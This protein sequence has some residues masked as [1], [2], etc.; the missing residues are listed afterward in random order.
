[1]NLTANL[2]KTA[3]TPVRMVIENNDK[4]LHKMRLE[5]KKRLH[6]YEETEDFGEIDK[7]NVP[8]EEDAPAEEDAPTEEPSTE[9]VETTSQVSENSSASKVELKAI[10]SYKLQDLQNLMSK[11]GLT[12]QKTASNGKMKNKTKKECYDELSAL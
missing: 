7:A 5:Q 4:R 2:Q 10:A 6:E 9:V 3:R 1:M 12:T 11:Y 8:V